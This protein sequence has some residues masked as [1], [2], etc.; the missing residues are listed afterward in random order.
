MRLLDSD[1]LAYALY[2]ES[3]AHQDAWSFLEKGLLGELEVWVT[4]TTILEAYNVLFWFYRVRPPEKVLEKLGVAV[5]GLKVVAPSIA[6]IE[7]SVNENIPLGDGFLI[8][9]A[10]ESRLPVVVSNDRHIADKAPRYG[11]IV[12]NPIP[13]RVRKEMGAWKG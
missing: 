7:I 12:E 11:L 9:S 2:D 13:E 6:G 1:V 3:P 4:H 10:L 8:A 5:S